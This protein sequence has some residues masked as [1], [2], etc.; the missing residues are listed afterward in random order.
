MTGNLRSLLTNRRFAIPL[1][2]L[3]GFCFIGLLMIGFV[4]IFRPGAETKADTEARIAA[5]APTSP[6]AKRTS[7]PIPEASSTSTPRPTLTPFSTST[8]EAT[9]EAASTTVAMTTATPTS[10]SEA[11]PTETPTATA[12]EGTSE[13][14]ASPE[15]EETGDDEL[16]QTGIGWGLV[17]ISAVGLAG[18]VIVARRLRLA[19]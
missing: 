9:E 4:L 12:E 1:I 15:P 17:F 7:S 16:A 18:L 13:P 6:T 3:L 5:V 14:T 2:V 8:K 10:E 19:S 11:G